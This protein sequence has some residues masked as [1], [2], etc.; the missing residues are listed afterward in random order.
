MSVKTYVLK[1]HTNSTAPIYHRISKDQRVRFEKRPLDHAYLKLTFYENKTQKNRT[2]RLKLSSNTIWQDEQIKEGILANESF[3][4][5]ERNAVKFVNGVLMTKNEIVQQ[6]LEAIP[7]FDKF[8]GMCDSIKEPLYELYDKSVEMKAATDEFKKRLKAANK[9]AEIEDLKTGQDLMIRLNG[10]FFKTPDNLDEVIAGLI[11]YLDDAD[12]AMLDK[13]INDSMTKDEELIILVGRAVAADVIS[14]DQ[15]PNQVALKKGNNW[16]PVKMIS[17]DLPASERQR[18][19]VEFLSTNDGK[20]LQDDLK[21]HLD[22]KTEK[23][24]KELVT[25]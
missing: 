10:S 21:K 22:G 18:F 17:S 11:S 1:S 3:T 15:L 7:Q 24:K 19:F 23:K 16:I 14:F 5:A 4:D 25:E 8:E 2:A 13:I 12:E 6:Y 9:I 20:L